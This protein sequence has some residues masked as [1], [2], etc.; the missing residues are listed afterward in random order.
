MDDDHSIR[1]TGSLWRVSASTMAWAQVVWRLAPWA[2]SLAS[3][4]ARPAFLSAAGWAGRHSTKARTQDRPSEAIV[5]CYTLTN[6]SARLD[7]G[8]EWAGFLYG[9]GA[10]M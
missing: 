6:R 8:R 5:T 9:P 4:R 10:A 7:S 2:L 3:I 1:Q